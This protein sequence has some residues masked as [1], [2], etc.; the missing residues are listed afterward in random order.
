MNRF[1]SSDPDEAEVVDFDVVDVDEA[2][3]GSSGISVL[4]SSSL[5][6][7]IFCP[8]LCLNKSARDRGLKV[9]VALVV[10]GGSV[11]I[12]NRLTL[13]VVVVRVLVSTSG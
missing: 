1:L 13:G 8:S 6:P 9:V 7:P 3:L 2:V 10:I 4:L 12:L 5:D 11:L